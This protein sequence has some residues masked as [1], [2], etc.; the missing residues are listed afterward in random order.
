MML[1]QG[2]TGDEVSWNFL[3]EYGILNK[4]SRRYELVVV[5]E[6]FYRYALEDR[7]YIQ[8]FSAFGKSV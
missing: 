7:G 1:L 6:M 5:G 8:F 3:K 4:G 2:M